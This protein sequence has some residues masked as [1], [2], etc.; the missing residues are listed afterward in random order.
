MCAGAPDFE[1]V[2]HVL[3]HGLAVT[4]PDQRPAA[5]DV[6]NHASCRVAVDAAKAGLIIAGEQR[7]GL[8][9]VPTE[10]FARAH[11]H[12]VHPLG[13][14]PK[15][16]PNGASSVRIVHD[17]SSPAHDCLNA[18]IDYLRLSYDRVDATFA[19]LQSGDFM[20][21]I[22]IAAFFRHIPMDPADWGLL[23]FRW[24]GQ[25]FIDTRLNFGQRNAPECAMRFSNTVMW[26]VRQ[27]LQEREVGPCSVYVV[28]DDWLVVADSHSRCHFVWRLII[29]MLR[30]FG[31]AVNDE[32]HKCIAPTHVLTWLGLEVDSAMMTVRLPHEKVEKALGRVASVAAATKVTRRDLDSLFG[33]LSYCCAVVYGGRAFLHGLRRLR[34]RGGLPDKGVRAA[35]HH[36]HVNVGLRADLLWWQEHLVLFNG[37]RRVP[38]VSL[39]IAHREEDIFIDARGGTGGVGVFVN[40]GFVGLTGEQ[41]NERYPLGSELVSPGSWVSPSTEANHWEMFAFCVLLDLFPLVLQ[42]RFVVVDSDS[43]SAIKCVRDLSAS[44]DSLPL[45]CLTR[46]FLS[47]TVKLNVRVLPRHIAGSLNVLADPLSRG[48]WPQFGTSANAWC[49]A[50]GWACS[51]YLREL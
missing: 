2:H 22:D 28:C 29:D 13:L 24:D 14:I 31:F 20:A 45:A 35:K 47:M 49:L 34:F 50:K 17:T 42:N 18:H 43:M 37:D 6:P 38:I 44:L 23:A 51:T 21:K 16:K 10:W 4:A 7:D 5:Y 46:T 19:A 41:C 8:I 1:F 30:G 9:S 39:H 12:W 32:P 26:A 11:C 3:V 40:G 33:Y 15:I 48:M 36:V 27:Q 25:L